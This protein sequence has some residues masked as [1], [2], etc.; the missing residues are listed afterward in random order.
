MHVHIP[1]NPTRY[2]NKASI[3]PVRARPVYHTTTALPKIP[4]HITFV[5]PPLRFRAQ[6]SIH[7]FTHS[8]KPH[9]PQPFPT[10]KVNIPPSFPAP[11]TS[12]RN[13]SDP[14][15]P[16]ADSDLPYQ[17]P[18]R[19][20]HL[21]ALRCSKPDHARVRVRG[22]I[23]G[24]LRGTKREDALVAQERRLLLRVVV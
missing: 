1:Y 18:P 15:I 10:H 24:S 19:G 4:G 20:P 21:H 5:S 22:D 13:P 11:P 9:A 8:P 14:P 2:L 23:A 12:K 17:L 3:T 16:L 7:H 6:S